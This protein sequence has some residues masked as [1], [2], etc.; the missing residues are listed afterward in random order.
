MN[1]SQEMQK[2]DKDVIQARRLEGWITIL[3]YAVIIVLL[4]W[5]TLRFDWPVWIVSFAI[6]WTIL[7]IPFELVFLPQCKYKFWRY[8]I[9][10]HEIELHHGI[11]FRKR[12]IIPM[13]RIQHIDAKQGPILKRYGLSTIT[14]STAAGSHDIPALKES[15]A[16]HVRKYIAA[17]ARITNEDI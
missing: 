8:R 6:I 13:I 1:S 4:Y 10:E 5:L 17:L 15:K 12:T 9:S 2:I 7:S 3:V 14:F 11:F 16:E